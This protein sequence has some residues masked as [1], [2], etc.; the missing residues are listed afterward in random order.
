MSRAAMTRPAW[1]LVY[2]ALRVLLFEIFKVVMNSEIIFGHTMPEND[3]AIHRNFEVFTTQRLFTSRSMLIFVDV[4]V[5]PLEYLRN[6]TSQN[7]A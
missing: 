4:F 1:L 6:I 7:C 5:F 3:S 2:S